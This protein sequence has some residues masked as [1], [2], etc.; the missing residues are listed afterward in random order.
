MPRR[1]ACPPTNSAS[2]SNSNSKR[3]DRPGGGAG[4]AYIDAGASTLELGAVPDGAACVPGC[5]PEGMQC[6]EAAEPARGCS[7]PPSRLCEMLRE[8]EAVRARMSPCV[9]PACDL[10]E[11]GACAC[12]FLV[13]RAQ[14]RAGPRYSLSFSHWYNEVIVDAQA[15]ARD[16]PAAI[17]GFF[18]MGNGAQP[19][20][21]LLTASNRLVRA[22]HTEFLRKFGLDEATGPPLLMLDP[23]REQ[24]FS[25]ATG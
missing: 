14:V 12:G 18:L 22:A 3:C 10:H 24:P 25:L 23:E 19:A 4:S 11:C 7:F 20:G 16:P 1:H 2:G 21:K 8:W 5:F 17:E 13:W 15:V 6:G 9:H